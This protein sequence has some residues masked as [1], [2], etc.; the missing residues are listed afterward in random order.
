MST[1]N[2]PSLPMP[3]SMPPPRLPQSLYSLKALIYIEHSY[4][5]RYQILLDRGYCLA[6]SRQETRNTEVVSRRESLRLG[7]L[8]KHDLIVKRGLQIKPLPL[9]IIFYHA[10]GSVAL[11]L[12]FCYVIVSL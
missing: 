8:L 9:I 10:P 3:P 7:A 5:L 6:L 4:C 2:L 12:P 1:I 11:N